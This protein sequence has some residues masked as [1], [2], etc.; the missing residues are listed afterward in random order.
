[1]SIIMTDTGHFWLSRES[2]G[3]KNL[4][5]EIPYYLTDITE[6]LNKERLSISGYLGGMKVFIYESGIS[7]RGSLAK[8]FLKDNFQ[9]LF[10][11]DIQRAIEK[12]SDEIHLPV[13]KSKVTRID[14][15]QNFITNYKPE[16]YY[17][18]LGDSRYFKRF[19]LPQSLYYSNNS[20]TKLFY[21]KIIEGRKKG[22]CIPDV[23]LDSH[24]L[25]Y[26][27]RLK[28]KAIGC[29]KW[30]KIEAKDLFDETVYI[31]LINEFVKEYDNINKLNHF[32]FNLENMKTPNDFIIQLALLKIQ[33]IGQNDIMR[34][35]EDLRVKKVFNKKEY[36]SRLKSKIRDLCKQP[37]ITESSDLIDE[38]SQKIRAVKQ[39]YR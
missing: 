27:Y 14:I 1:M 19:V 35:V 4:L 23:W 36:Y 21:N 22:Y 31:H 39:N 28:G 34:M 30:N 29:P 13:I 38:L 18:L 7:I 11:S 26:E 9:T 8:Y 32:N 20:R 33:E 6:H 10:R 2:A 5:V 12:M 24:V 16:S 17:D 15:A 37:E 3:N 25:R